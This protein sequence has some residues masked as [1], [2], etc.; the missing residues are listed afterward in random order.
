MNING[1]FIFYFIVII[2]VQMSSDSPVGKVL[3]HIGEITG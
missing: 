3:P 2:F 1:K